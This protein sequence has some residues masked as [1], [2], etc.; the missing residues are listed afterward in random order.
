MKGNVM[1]ESELAFARIV[2]GKCTIL[3]SGELVTR[4]NEELSDGKPTTYTVLRN[5]CQAG[6]F[7]NKQALVSVLVSE[8]D[9]LARESGANRK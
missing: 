4:R 6:I 3:P 7:E 8:E 2:W 9:Y 5:L 1:S